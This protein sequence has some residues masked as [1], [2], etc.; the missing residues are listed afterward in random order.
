M[1][2]VGGSL[3]GR[4][5]EGP[6]D[7]R[8]RPTSDRVREAIFNVLAHRDLGGGFTLEGAR[9]LDLFA[10]TGALGIEAVSRGARFCLF[11][12]DHLESRAIIRRNVEAFSLTGVTKIWRR[13]ASSLGPVEPN[14]NGPFDLLFADPPYRMNLLGPA[15]LSAREGGWL[16][17]H[18]VCV[19]ELAADEAFAP[20][21]G[22][23]VADDRTHGETRVLMLRL[24]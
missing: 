16:Q 3:R 21:F 13:D 11:I 14:A 24:G 15:L 22:F 8:V 10:G 2:V 19:A 1:R 7:A 5:I 4:T 12:D 20:P 6:K 23:V 18:A 9:V 17:P